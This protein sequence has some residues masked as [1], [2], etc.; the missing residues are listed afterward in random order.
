MVTLNHLLD[1]AVG[2][3]KNV[4][5]LHID[6][7]ADCGLWDVINQQ[8]LAGLL[9]LRRVGSLL[10]DLPSLGGRRRHMLNTIYQHLYQEIGLVGYH[11]SPGTSGS[12]GT[13][14]SE[15]TGQAVAAGMANADLGAEAQ[16]GKRILYPLGR[17][18]SGHE[19]LIPALR[20][21]F[22]RVL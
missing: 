21:G 1:L 7:G 16:G 15:D 17:M 8:P 12:F 9:A 5:L 3:G 2:P 20:L 6:C 19:R 10:V 18:G 11:W 22:V 14:G 4:T 13:A